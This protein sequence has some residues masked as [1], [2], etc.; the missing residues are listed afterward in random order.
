MLSKCIKYSKLQLRMCKHEIKNF[1]KIGWL[2][3][4][5]SLHNALWTPVYLSSNACYKI[6]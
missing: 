2:V 1:I 6:I 3:A 5:T 4:L